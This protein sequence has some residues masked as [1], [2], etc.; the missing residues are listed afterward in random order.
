LFRTNPEKAG[1]EI[2]DSLAMFDD[3]QPV[4]SVEEN[5]IRFV[6]QTVWLHFK[7]VIIFSRILAS[8]RGLC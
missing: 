5:P 1:E 8:N 4:I 6:I 3:T 2:M 7:E